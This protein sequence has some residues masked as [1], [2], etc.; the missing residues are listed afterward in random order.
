[1]PVATATL[2]LIEGNHDTDGKGPVHGAQWLLAGHNVF[3]ENYR[4]GTIDGRFGQTTGE[5]CVRA[6]RALG[7]PPDA[8]RPTFGPKLRAYLLG[9]TPLP[10][11]YVERR[12]EG[13]AQAPTFVYPA[14]MRVPLL[15]RPGQ[16]TH[17][18][19][20]QP[21]NWQSDNAWDFSFPLGT[22]LV[23]VADGVIGNKIGP[24]STDPNSRF[25]GLR[26]Y[27]ETADNEFYYAHLS[28]FVP[29]TV[30]G[31]HVRQGDVLGFSGSASGVAHLHLGCRNW[32]AF[33][34]IAE[35]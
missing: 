6:K 12:R 17:S 4:P 31:A 7:Y 21:N 20:A 34:A 27:L 26:C 24:I 28:R 14:Q 13:A 3:K 18:W 15:G 8:C 23:A 30:A 11:P 19:T 29:S 35:R 10:A 32:R 25:G 2:V 5:A 1:M 16:G 9:E 33:E 22:P